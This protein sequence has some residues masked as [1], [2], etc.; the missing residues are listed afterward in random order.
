V[1][2]SRDIRTGYFDGFALVTKADSKK[3]VVKAYHTDHARLRSTLIFRA[4]PTLSLLRECETE[5]LRRSDPPT[6]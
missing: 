5:A 4:A 3:F 6:L 2:I 1:A